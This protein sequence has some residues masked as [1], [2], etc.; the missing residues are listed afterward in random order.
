MFSAAASTA[1]V[2]TGSAGRTGRSAS[3]STTEAWYVTESRYG[4]WK[5][6]DQR[7]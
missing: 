4:I 3:S 1:R 5:N 2:S 6:V 7:L